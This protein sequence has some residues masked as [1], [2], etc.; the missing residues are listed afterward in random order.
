[1][2]GVSMKEKEQQESK[3]KFEAIKKMRESGLKATNLADKGIKSIGFVG[4]VRRPSSVPAQDEDDGDS[5][6]VN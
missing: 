6:A 2:I 1:M 4:G 5:R 3:T